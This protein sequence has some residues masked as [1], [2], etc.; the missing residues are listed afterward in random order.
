MKPKL[1]INDIAKV[2][3]CT[4][5]NVHMTIK[6][7][8]IKTEKVSNRV[9]ISDPQEFRKICSL[10]IPK[11]TICVQTAKGGVGKTAIA[12]GLSTR[13]WQYGAKILV[14]DIDQQANLTK[15]FMHTKPEFVLMDV[16][17]GKCKIKNSIVELKN[18]LSLIPSSIKNSILGQYMIGM[19]LDASS[20]I[21]DLIE[22]IKDNFDI[23]IFDCPPSI[24]HHITSCIYASDMVI[25]PIDPDDDAI[26]GMKYL[27]AEV[28]K[29]N[30]K[31]KKNREFKILLNKYDQ[32]TIMSTRILNNLL[33][34]E[35][36]KDCLFDTIIGVSQE[37]T[38]AKNDR[39]TIFDPLKQSKGAKDIDRV[40][41][42]ILG[43][44]INEDES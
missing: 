37:F 26:D 24:G 41:L 7:K 25:S 32:R 36:L 8:R 15:N 19:G 17:E 13:L 16:L 28:L 29:I 9:Y 31:S 12:T 38:Q 6:E 22:P 40:T 1:L 35:E 34:F 14:I 3:D 11:H 33:E 2:M 23:I 20:T 44:K 4:V 10:P 21:S 42:E 18:G 30:K 27:Y 39:I 5:P 43:L